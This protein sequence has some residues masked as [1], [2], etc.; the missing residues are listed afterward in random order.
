[1]SPAC[2]AAVPANLRTFRA[3]T[4]SSLRV[5]AFSRAGPATS[6]LILAAALL[7]ASLLPQVTSAANRRYVEHSVPA[8]SAPLPFSDAVLS[9][10]TLYVAG[11]IGIDT[12]TGNA[13]ADPAVEAHL[14]MDAVKRTVE[15]AGLTMDDLVSVT[16]Y[17]TDLGLYDTFNAVYRT[18]FHG[19]Y[20]ARAFIGSSKLLRNGHF[21]VQGVALKSSP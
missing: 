13:P 9:G 1:M 10:D 20:P 12:H 16:V 17:C 3:A 11:H 19:H 2:R 18:Y 7:A 21:E 14:V 4:G 5:R 8:G 6:A 15:S